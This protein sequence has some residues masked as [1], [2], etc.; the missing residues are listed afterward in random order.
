MMNQIN[1]RSPL[2]LNAH[3]KLY[4]RVYVLIIKL[5]SIQFK[6]LSK[7]FYSSSDSSE[8]ENSLKLSMICLI[9]F[10]SMN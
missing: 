9:N 6:Y 10:F 4:K 7:S 5:K 3:F 2:A 8:E 1:S